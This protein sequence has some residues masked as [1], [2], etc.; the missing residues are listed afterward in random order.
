MIYIVSFDV[1]YFISVKFT[2][3]KVT[4][5]NYLEGICF[6]IFSYISFFVDHLEEKLYLQNLYELCLNLLF[7][8]YFFIEYTQTI[9][10]YSVLRL[11]FYVVKI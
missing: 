7:V 3:G 8:Y 4:D 1:R 10:F 9:I 5:S 6:V 11:L 2:K